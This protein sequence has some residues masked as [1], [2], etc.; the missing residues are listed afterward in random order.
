MKKIIKLTAI[1]AVVSSAVFGVTGCGVGANALKH[2]HSSFT[3]LNHKITL[4]S[5]NGAVI[6]EWVTQAKVE[7][8]GGTCFFLDDKDKAVTISG[9]FVVQEQ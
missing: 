2:L 9:T 6:K 3:G 4:Y 7:D 1:L 5:A 8:N